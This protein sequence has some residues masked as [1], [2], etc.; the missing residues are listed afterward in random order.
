MYDYCIYSVKLKM[1]SDFEKIIRFV[2]E[3]S[4]PG[5]VRMNGI[6]GSKQYLLLGMLNK[7]CEPGTEYG[8]MM[9]T[10]RLVKIKKR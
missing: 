2:R 9:S 7:K 1:N 6:Y 8:L 3:Y 10:G 4:K 5:S